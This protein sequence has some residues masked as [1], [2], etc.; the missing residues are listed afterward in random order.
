M[1]LFNVTWSLQVEKILPPILVARS[2]TETGDDFTVGEPENQY[3]EYLL[4]SSEG[5][6]KEFP[7]IGVNLWQYL[8][9]NTSPQIIES[10]IKRNMQAD[11]FKNPLVD[12]SAFPVIKV[13]KVIVEL[14]T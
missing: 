4:F 12:A 2:F 1:G 3:I 10:K 5:H 8:Q 6:W 9:G 14:T 13:N 11:V 7:T